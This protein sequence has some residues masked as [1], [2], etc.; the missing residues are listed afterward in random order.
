LQESIQAGARDIRI[1]EASGDD[2][3]VIQ[4][5]FQ[6]TAQFDNDQLLRG[7]AR[8]MQGVRPMRTVFRFFV[9]SSR[10]CH[11]VDCGLADAIAF[12]QFALRHACRT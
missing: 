3:Q 4:G 12:H 8:R 7:G 11:F 6:Q 5:Q 9:S 10:L 2:Q 1:D